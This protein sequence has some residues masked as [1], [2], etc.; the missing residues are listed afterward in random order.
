MEVALRAVLLGQARLRRPAEDR[1]LNQE[2]LHGHGD[3]RRAARS[4]PGREVFGSRLLGERPQQLEHLTQGRIGRDR[5][6]GYGVE[7][8]PLGQRGVWLPCFELRAVDDQAPPLS[9][10]RRAVELHHGHQC[11][12]LH[13]LFRF[14]GW[15]AKPV[16]GAREQRRE[17]LRRDHGEAQFNTLPVTR[18]RR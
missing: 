18:R 12:E 6:L 3:P 17:F 9:G 14:R 5:D 15:V 4:Q 1:G 2:G 8:E 7:L 16:Q 11:A 10:D 13:L